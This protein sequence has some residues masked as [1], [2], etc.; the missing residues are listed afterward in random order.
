MTEATVKNLL[1]ELGID[2]DG[3]IGTD[4]TWTGSILEYN[5]FGKIYSK[6]EK[7]DL[8]EEIPSTSLI[9]LHATDVTY[10]TTDDKLMIKMIGDLD[11][12]EY[13]LVIQPLM[14][15]DAAD[16]E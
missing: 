6:L 11:S 16:D 9:N 13:K 4:G 5:D 8:V 14:G 10:Q 15:A 1:K 12:D 2:L 3:V 7:S